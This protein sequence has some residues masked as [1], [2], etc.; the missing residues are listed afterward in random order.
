[1]YLSKTIPIC[2]HGEAG[3]EFYSRLLSVLTFSRIC[4]I[5]TPRCVDCNCNPYIPETKAITQPQVSLS[6]HEITRTFITDQP[7]LLSSLF[8][9][10]YTY[11][12]VTHLGGHRC[13]RWGPMAMNFIGSNLEINQGHMPLDKLGTR[14]LAILLGWNGYGIGLMTMRISLVWSL[15][16]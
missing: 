12:K 15:M 1:M 2:W 3:Q 13:R 4:L 7:I 9:W 5:V 10:G 11:Q 8:S 14:N 16:N 6:R